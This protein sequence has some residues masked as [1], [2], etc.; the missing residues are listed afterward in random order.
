MFNCVSERGPRLFEEESITYLF[1]KRSWDY[2]IFMFII[3]KKILT[4]TSYHISK[5]TQ[6]ALY[7]KHNHYNV[8]IIEGNMNKTLQLWGI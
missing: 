2:C 6:N 5:L 8:I 4:F 7:T 1:N 3:N